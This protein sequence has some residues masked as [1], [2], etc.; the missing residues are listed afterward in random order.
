MPNYR[1]IEGSYTQIVG[2]ETRLFVAGTSNDIVELTEQTAKRLGPT[3][4]KVDANEMDVAKTDS[5]QAF[6]EFL[7]QPADKIEQLLPTIHD[8]VVLAE[9]HALEEKTKARPEVLEAIDERYDEVQEEH[10]RV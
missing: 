2:K 10:S 9:F 1:I 7:E 4:V 6:T 3:F 5:G 8:P